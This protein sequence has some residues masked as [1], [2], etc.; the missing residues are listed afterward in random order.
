MNRTRAIRFLQRRSLMLSLLTVIPFAIAM[1]G[2]TACVKHPVGD[3]DSSKVDARFSGVWLSTDAVGH[4]TL[5]AMRPYDARTYLIRTLNFHGEAPDIVADTRSDWKA[6]LTPIGD[7]TFLTMEP[8]RFLPSAGTGDRPAYFVARIDLVDGK[9][10]LH[11]LNGT[12]GPAGKAND[13]AELEAAIAE[14][15]DSPSLYIGDVL[16]FEKE[17]DEGLLQGVLEAFHSDDS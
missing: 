15:I 4:R 9:L 6:W 12:S 10:R 14:Q 11:L 8:L 7:A 13:R 3:P 2:L 17:Q 5:M 1:L 16:V